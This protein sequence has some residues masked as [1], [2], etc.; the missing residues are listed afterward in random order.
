MTPF[1]MHS[2]ILIVCCFVCSCNAMDPQ[3]QN[4]SAQ[5]DAYYNLM[6]WYAHYAEQHRLCNRALGKET[7]ER[8]VTV[9]F[10]KKCGIS[11][12]YE[13][14]CWWYKTN[15]HTTELGSFTK[16][17]PIFK[18]QKCELEEKIDS[19]RVQ[20]REMGVQVSEQNKLLAYIDKK[21]K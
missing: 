19:I 5:Q 3:K 2:I 15:A 20:L 17:R 4:A 7:Q 18:A 21:Q 16:L 9:E 1:S 12:P 8:K 6:G 14:Y 13:T 10:L 11:I